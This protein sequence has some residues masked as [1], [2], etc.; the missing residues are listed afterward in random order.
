LANIARFKIEEVAED[1]EPIAAAKNAKLF[2]SQCGVIVRDNIPITVREWRKPKVDGV[3]YVEDRSKE[4]LRNTLMAHFTLPEEVDPLNKV[5]KRKVRAWALKK[6]AVQF[7]NHKKR[8]H[9]DDILKE[10]T[11]EFTGANV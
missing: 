1:G 2:V 5:I 4:D 8:F 6:M 9:R 10:K 11:P 3:S 7:N